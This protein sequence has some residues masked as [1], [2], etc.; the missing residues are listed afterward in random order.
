[1]IAIYIGQARRLWISK[2]SASLHLF[3]KKLTHSRM[4]KPTRSPEFFSSLSLG[5]KSE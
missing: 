5:Y 1:M 2:Q 4:C 3:L